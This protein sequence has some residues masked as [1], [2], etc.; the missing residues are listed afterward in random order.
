M[1][2]PRAKAGRPCLP[3]SFFKEGVTVPLP[4]PTF[5]QT[6]K[7]SRWRSALVL[8]IAGLKLRFRRNPGFV[9][10]TAA[11]S[12]GLVLALLLLLNGGLKYFSKSGALEEPETPVADLGGEADPFE[13]SDSA[14]A[15][16]PE[17]QPASA[18][19]TIV[20]KE[21]PQSP[22]DRDGAFL[23]DS[24]DVDDADSATSVV[25]R[26]VVPKVSTDDVEMGADPF[27]GDDATTAPVEKEEEKAEPISVPV[28]AAPQSTAI[29]GLHDDA[30]EEM[31]ADD[32]ILPQRDVD[33]RLLTQND[34]DAE[35]ADAEEAPLPAKA[36]PPAAKHSESLFGDDEPI[37]GSDDEEP[38]PPISKPGTTTIV[39]TPA[40]ASPPVP[41]ATEIDD[42]SFAPPQAKDADPS[43]EEPAVSGAKSGWKY[44]TTKPQKPA[45][46][47]AASQ[48]QAVET[49]VY[50]APE[51]KPVV[52]AAPKA[53][54]APV[55]ARQEQTELPVSLSIRA[56]GG[57]AR[58]G[59]FDLEF[60]VTNHG[61]EAL[62]GVNLTVLLPSGLSHDL[63]PELEQPIEVLAPGQTHR[64]RLTVKATGSG[65]VTPRADVT[66]KGKPWWRKTT[67]TLRVGTPAATGSSLPP[68]A[69]EPG[70]RYV[71]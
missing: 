27:N 46:E 2:A 71:W 52:P 38:S 32:S 53:A 8:M 28:A 1:I 7:R 34:A 37:S 18:K 6:D 13:K 5:F 40:K 51:T 61:R 62:H 45:A 66:I 3:R 63:G 35:P 15:K 41:P 60:L 11:G 50:A 14:L 31:E 25:S 36:S 47:P 54:P 4:K 57:V 29:A 56:P 48:S 59:S 12:I 17:P 26:S 64:A 16:D 42:E 23:S 21:R 55:P 19:R 33:E 49:A 10:A 69:C 24:E 30:E 67:T 58:G 39:T 20:E 68:C 22:P 65:D 44:S 43:P 70:F 9:T